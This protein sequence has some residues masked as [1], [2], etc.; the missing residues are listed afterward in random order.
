MRHLLLLTIVLLLAG[1]S[2]VL[3]RWP[4]GAQY[5]FSQHAAQT[6][7]ASIFYAL[8]FLITS[9]ILVLYFGFWFI[10]TFQAPQI[11]LY[12]IILVGIFQVA[13]TLAPERGSK[14][15]VLAHR[16]LA[17]VSGA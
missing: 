17:G 10:P 14:R 6:K 9:P 11:L 8:L 7:S 4:R 16:L 1:L 12:V 15:R 3:Y 13:C 2:F 5:S